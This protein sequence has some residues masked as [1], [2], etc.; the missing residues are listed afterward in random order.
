[1][2]KLIADQTQRSII[3]DDELEKVIKKI[4]L[5]NP[6]A[7]ADYKSG[8]ENVLMFLLG[9]VMRGVKGKSNA[10]DI[11]QKLKLLLNLYPDV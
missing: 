1:M 2:L 9:Q 4:L 8:K 11:K 5:E 6:R 3:P 7:M 10:E